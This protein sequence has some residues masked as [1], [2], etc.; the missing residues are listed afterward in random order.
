MTRKK[1][2]E[3]KAQTVPSDEPTNNEAVA[4][5]PSSSTPNEPEATE[6]VSELVNGVTNLS[7]TDKERGEMDRQTKSKEQIKA[8][9]EA[10]KAEKANKKANATSK[11]VAS[12]A[13]QIQQHAP[14][15]PNGQTLLSTTQVSKLENKKDVTQ[16]PP[17]PE[18]KSAIKK[19]TARGNREVQ[20]DL[21]TTVLRTPS[22][23]TI[24]DLPKMCER[25]QVADVDDLCEEFLGAFIKFISDWGAERLHN[26]D[27]D[28]TALGF[29]LDLAIRPQLGYLTEDGRWPLPY[30]L[31]NLVR[32]LKREIKRLDEPCKH[33]HT[34]EDGTVAAELPGGCDKLKELEE[35]LEEARYS[36]FEL[37]TNSISTHLMQKRKFSKKIVTFDWCRVVN[38]ILLDSLVG[39]DPDLKHIVVL[40]QQLNGRGVRHMDTLLD[41]NVKLDYGDLRS[42]SVALHKCSI[43]LIG[44]S[45]VLS[46]GCVAVPK[47]SLSI[48]LSA[49]ANNIPFMVCA[50]TFKFVDKVQTYGRMALLGRENME[51]VPSSL[52]T[53]IVTDIR[54]VPPSSAPAIL[55][56]KAL[57]SQN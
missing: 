43:V 14:Q 46:N 1:T 22:E 10:K 52:I 49:Q 37:A 38:R 36:C 42:L 7:M 31:G 57:E 51:L 33:A 40:D 16:K 4:S 35:W 5:E 56:A 45:A 39:E 9:R 17:S 20:F 54:I 44:C 53:A 6:Q 27:A 2:I 19:D 30:A 11:V 3:K 24:S 29:D 55:K 26:S 13:P 28:P 32:Q 12:P 21:N 15:I 48:A 47:G 41:K 18:P 34:K 8:E 50:Q 25:G 23:E